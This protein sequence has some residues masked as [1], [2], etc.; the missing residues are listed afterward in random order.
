MLSTLEKLAKAG[1]LRLAMS[2]LEA[3]QDYKQRVIL[4]RRVEGLR[5]TILGQAVRSI[6]DLDLFDPDG[7]L[8]IIGQHWQG[9][10][11][12]P[13]AEVIQPAAYLAII[14]KYLLG[15]KAKIEG[16]PAAWDSE[17][18][19]LNRQIA[20]LALSAQRPEFRAQALRAFTEAGQD[21]QAVGQAARE[22]KAA[23]DAI[24]ERQKADLGRRMQL[25]REEQER[26]M[27][28]VQ[29]LLE[30]WQVAHRDLNRMPR[31][32]SAEDAFQ[33][34]S[35]RVAAMYEDYVATHRAQFDGFNV[36]VIPDP[37]LPEKQAAEA[38]LARTAE[39]LI[40]D[41]LAASPVTPDEATAWAAAQEVSQAAKARL[42]KQGYTEAALRADMAEFYR[43]CGGRLAKVLIRSNGGKRA[44]AEGIH[45]HSSSIINIDGNF[46]KRTL[47][48]ELA[49][50]L[51]ADPVVLAAGKGFLE[52]KRESATKYSLRS[53]T[54][55]KGYRAN[56]GAYRDHFIDPYVG[57]V[58][59]DATEVFSMG[60]ESFS[61]PL[62]LAKRIATDP[63]HF[64]LM[65][66]FTRTRPDPLFGSVKRVFTQM[67][68]AEAEADEA[69]AEELSAGIA[70][71]A[72][73]VE[74]VPRV[75]RDELPWTAGDWGATYIGNFQDIAAYQCKSIRD[76]AT[77]RKKA[78]IALVKT[79]LTP[80]GRRYQRA[81]FYFGGL[82]QAK[83]AALVWSR[84]SG[85]F[86]PSMTT[87]EKVVNYV[88]TYAP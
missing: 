79:G 51:E 35:R 60:M 83:A 26:R 63:E 86:A 17:A 41:T 43:L 73:A 59:T 44:S 6:T 64:A 75:A 85:P 80:D 23:V 71:L 48:H 15:V 57:K 76:P 30:A 56:E 49:H 53:L 22:A 42:R 20:E 50:H 81:A 40:A 4:G 55:N 74:F 12:K 62:T 82:E 87:P 24:T 46:T 21:V 61:D 32:G 47:F 7:S 11:G 29:P 8:A 1:D 72:A 13:A 16:G 36:S 88:R 39:S 9:L 2:G 37:L 28:I 52:K 18:A 14:T 66:G 19:M 65:V 10:A 84:D 25:L 78:G 70:K 58:Y 31:G 67:A 54:G 3:A 34:E 27:A 77:K 68:D 33:A 69:G 38:Q 45:G 5:A